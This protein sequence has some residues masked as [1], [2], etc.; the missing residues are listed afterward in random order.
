MPVVTV[1]RQ[2]ASGGGE[3]AQ[4]VAQILDAPLL[5]R[6]LIY[7]VALRLGLPEDV[8]SEHDE[9]GETLISRLVNALRVSYPDASSPPDLVEA[10]GDVMDLSN[11]TYV[12]VTEQVIQE[13]ARSS[14]AVIVG[15]GSQFV[16][17][18]HPRAL[19]VHI[20]APFDLR[21]LS[22]VKEQGVSRQEAE[23]IVRDFDGARAR[24]ARHFYHA[25]WQA[26]QNYHL[27]I[28]AGYV[29]RELAADLICQTA[30]SM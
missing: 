5:D 14:N 16:L 27:L 24:Y 8:V 20:Y 12:Q 21:A 3:I 18:N 29:G 4:R 28:N 25:D 2:F 9:R 30:R 11:R 13:A 6:Q 10:P 17:R 26:P 19:H 22:V 23:R 15:R 1:S 7:E